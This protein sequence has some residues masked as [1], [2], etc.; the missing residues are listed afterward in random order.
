MLPR[1]DASIPT[2]GRDHYPTWHGPFNRV[3]GLAEALVPGLEDAYYCGA[4]LRRSAGQEVPLAMGDGVAASFRAVA[5]RVEHHPADG[6]GHYPVEQ[7]PDLVN[8]L[9]LDFLDGTR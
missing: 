2:S 7:R 5:T 1:I 4:F 8:G 6:A 3:A 9:L